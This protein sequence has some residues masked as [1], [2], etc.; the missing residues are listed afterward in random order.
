MMDA[1]RLSVPDHAGSLGAM[2]IHISESL[3]DDLT[4]AC[5]RLEHGATAEDAKAVTEAVSQLV[6]ELTNAKYA[7]AV[8]THIEKGGKP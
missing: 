2:T 5:D 7:H 3:V 8:R 4:R 6:G 1:I